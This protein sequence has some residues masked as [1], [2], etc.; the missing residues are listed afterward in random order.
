MSK[1]HLH[2]ISVAGGS[3]GEITYDLIPY[4]QREFVVTGIDDIPEQR[5]ILFCHFI[6]RV[7]I[8]QPKHFN[9]FKKK[10]LIQ[11]IDGTVLTPYVIEAFNKFDLIFTPA[12]AGKTIMQQNGVT[13]P[14][15]VLPNFYKPDIFEKQIYHPIE[16]HIPA[17]KIIFYHESTFHPRKGIEIMYEAFIKAF[18]DN[19]WYDRV[20]LVLKDAPFNHRT[21]ASNEKLKKQAIALQKQYKHT[22]D[23]IK[24][25]AHLDEAEMK[26]LWGRCDAYVALSKLEGF[27]IPLLRMFLLNKP[28]ICLNNE[29]SGYMDYLNEKNSYMIDAFQVKAK[30]EFMWLYEDET[31]WAVPNVS[32]VVD[33]FQKVARDVMH[34]KAKCLKSTTDKT[35]ID[36]IYKKFSIDEVAN[37]YVNTIKEN[38]LNVV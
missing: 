31:T 8:E 32:D 24:F 26:A 3:I 38:F 19:Y 29:N 7:I 27:G 18:S 17:D 36:R 14:I 4:L 16:E 1:P 9:S 23:I 25:S 34:H 30:E 33:M 22:P 28:I 15:M 5:D 10:Y 20:A 37:Q 13:A 2:L 6:E 11:P 21:F 35:T 12:Q